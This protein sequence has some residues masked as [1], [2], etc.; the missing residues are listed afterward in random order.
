MTLKLE[1]GPHRLEFLREGFKTQL[2]ALTVASGD[3]LDLLV[4]LSAE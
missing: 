1:P 4:D 2:R 3:N